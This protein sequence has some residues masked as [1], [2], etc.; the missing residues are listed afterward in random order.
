MGRTLSYKPKAINDDI[1]IREHEDNTILYMDIMF[2]MG[3]AFL[4]SISKGYNV[5]VVRYINDRKMTTIENSIR[6]TLSSYSKYNVKINMIICDG[7]GAISALKA[8]IEGM[9]VQ[10]EQSSKNEHVATIE[11]AIRQIKERVRAYKNTLPYNITKEI[12]VYLVYYLVSMINNVP[13]STSVLEMSRKKNLLEKSWI[14][15]LISN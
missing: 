9:G 11:R 10:L 12:L 15:I 2:I 5:L 14:I 8:S 13:R 6:Q 1:F 3:L 7:E 4:V